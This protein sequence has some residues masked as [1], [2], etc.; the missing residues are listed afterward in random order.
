MRPETEY[1]NR[2]SLDF[3]SGSLRILIAGLTLTLLAACASPTLPPTP[4]PLPLAKELIVYDWEEDMPKSVL[5]AFTDEYGVK[6]RYETYVSQEEAIENMR[7]G[8]VYDVVVM[9]SRF[10]PAL[11]NDGL[12]GDLNHQ[13]I[14][15][16]KNISP[17]FR[18]LTYDPD[19][20]Y[21]IP[22]GWGMIG[23]LVRTDLAP[24]PVT[25]WADLWDTRYAG[26]M[27][28]W[29]DLPRETL[30]LTLKSLGYSAN[31][32]N[33]SELEAALAKLIAVKPDI[34]FLNEFDLISAAPAIAS[35]EIIAA[36]G[37]SGDFYASQ[38]LG[39]QVKYILPEEGALLWSDNLIIPA[40]SPN[41][42]S[43]ELFINFLLRPEI[44][45]EL[46]NQKGYAIANEAANEFIDPQIL[47]DPSIYPGN[48]LLEKAELILPLT[49]HGRQ[50]YKDIWERFS[51]AP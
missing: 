3:W 22:Y 39:L 1:C 8:Q 31:S 40:N 45:A 48:D 46:V 38:E 6:V 41:K 16:F 23:L 50:L 17:N 25:N 30:A 47:N 24:S 26:K 21:S 32:E 27:A 33:P 7:A 51:R 2:L 29:S 12:L 36:M 37:Y 18:G 20:R 19:N 11:V 14:L 9:E 5:D 28:I 15:N 10:I 13:N 44:G 42:T 35:G 43:A 34:R 49:T 4:T